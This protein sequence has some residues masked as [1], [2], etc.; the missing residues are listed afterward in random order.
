MNNCFC[1]SSNLALLP[2]SPDLEK[3]GLRQADSISCGLVEVTPEITIF[4]LTLN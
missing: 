2:L 4:I 3:A 1:W